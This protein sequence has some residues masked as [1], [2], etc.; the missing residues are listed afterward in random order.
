MNV[1]TPPPRWDPDADGVTGHMRERDEQLGRILAVREQERAAMTRAQ[2]ARDVEPVIHAPAGHL[3]EVATRAARSLP[4][5]LQ[6]LLDEPIRRHRPPRLDSAA[7]KDRLSELEARTLLALLLAAPVEPMGDDAADAAD[8]CEY[9]GLAIRNLPA[10]GHGG[11]RV[12]IDPEELRARRK[13]AGLGL[14]AL[15]RHAGEFLPGRTAD[16]VYAQLQR[17]ESGR[18]SS[19]HL[20]TFWAVSAILVAA[21]FEA[22]SNGR[23]TDSLAISR[24]RDKTGG[25]FPTGSVWNGSLALSN[26]EGL[27]S[28]VADG[29]E[30]VRPG[31]S[32]YVIPD[33]GEGYQETMINGEPGNERASWTAHEELLRAAQGDGRWHMA[34]IAA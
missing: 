3:A 19:F 1:R 7:P 2:V 18:S 22:A 9:L 13:A 32:R 10:K 33:K 25:A 17:A 14:R 26:V 16:S 15:A 24:G 21:E 6:M 28:K 5:P 34:A 27:Q 23:P 30:S 29:R 11:G 20:D 12:T 8:G 4:E 31:H